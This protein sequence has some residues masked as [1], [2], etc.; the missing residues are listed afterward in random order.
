MI[1]AG[2]LEFT[3]R[4]MMDILSVEEFQDTEFRLMDKNPDNLS[5][6]A[7]LCRNM[8]TENSLPAT[9]FET[10][11]QRE[12]LTGADYVIC[13]IR[14][15]GLSA[16]EKDITIPLKYNVDQCVGDTIGPGGVFYALRT[17]P[18]LLDIAEDMRE[19]APQAL[20][21]NY[22]NPMAMNTWALRRAGG[23]S[24]IGLCHGVQGG[25]RLIAKA[26]GVPEKELSI[27]AAGINHQTW[28]IQ[29]DHQGEDMIP[30][31]YETFQSHPEIVEKEPCRMDVLKRFG[32][33][34]TETNGHLSE[35]LPWYRKRP[36]ELDRW[37]DQ[38][39]WIGG[40]TA[41][42]LEDCKAKDGAYRRKAASR[43]IT[44]GD[45]TDEHA[46]Y[47]IEALETGRT[48]R[49][50]LNVGNNG[51]IMNLPGG[52]TV[53]LPCY[54]DQTGIHPVTI[55]NLPLPCAATCRSS[56]NVQEM[57]VEAA[58]RGD[59]EMVKLAVLHDPLTAAVCNT[60]EVWQM[61]DEMFEAHAAWLPQFNGENRKWNDIRQP[62]A[63]VF[64][65]RYK[66]EINAF[67]V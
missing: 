3:R 60:E 33:F 48:Y 62:D 7:G 6:I 22:A 52:S 41:G 26:L 59:K 65:N 39:D 46:S 37:I 44:L 16:Y 5:F 29:V 9:V 50:H 30:N 55:G 8:I 13:T 67:E 49:G 57:A 43:K 20:L 11:D 27:T 32:Y 21:L 14:V 35:Y 25:S 42:Y 66:Q 61:C 40:I 47:I 58:L 17:I 56:I 31:L 2:S 12:A 28:Y 19:V 45:R 1:G 53:E 51:Y 38:S 23:I 34:S 10:M 54:V 64:T 15:G 63:G 4:L 18:A 36:E 24:V